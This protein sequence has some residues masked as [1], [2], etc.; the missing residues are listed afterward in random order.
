MFHPDVLR[1][2]VENKLGVEAEEIYVRKG[3]PY[4]SEPATTRP[5]MLLISVFFTAWLALARWRG[6]WERAGIVVASIPLVVWSILVWTILFLIKIDWVRWNEALFLFLPTDIALF[7]LKDR[8]LRLYARARLGMVLVISLLCA[9]GL[10]RQPLWIP[11]LSA[12]LP[13]A[14]LAFDLPPRPGRVPAKT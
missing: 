2:A 4:Q 5:W 8:W 1:L 12:F 13:L 14:L 7:F 10:F 11:L 6:R 9:V 3:P